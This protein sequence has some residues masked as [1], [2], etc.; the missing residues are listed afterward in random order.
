MPA[1]STPSP[2]ARSGLAV[3]TLLLPVDPVHL[4]RRAVQP[5]LEQLAAALELAADAVDRRDPELA[6]LAQVEARA[7]ALA[8]PREALAAARDSIRLTL[9]PHRH[10]QRVARYAEIVAALELAVNNVRVMARGVGR[11][12]ALEDATPPQLATA[13][14]S[15]A[16]AVRALEAEDPDAAR[17]AALHAAEDAN[18]VLEET[19]NMSA[20]H[21]VGQLRSTAVD[22]MRAAGVE[23][24]EAV[25][26]VRGSTAG[27]V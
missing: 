19:G 12:L 18:A 9:R 6:E 26:G 24:A 22:L 5:L 20:L 1:S 17:R 8:R 2:A 23:H 10:R 3:A 25:S 4:V 21:I 16:E 14:R 13:L 11:A 15:L 27:G 7:I